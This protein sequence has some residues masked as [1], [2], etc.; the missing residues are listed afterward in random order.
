MMAAPLPHAPLPQV[1]LPRAPERLQRARA[2]QLMGAGVSRPRQAPTARRIAQRRVVVLMTK[3]SLPVL[4]LALLGSVALWPELARLKDQGRIAFRR[5][6]A[7]DPDSTRLKEPRYRG[8][9][10]RGRPFT[11]TGDWAQQTSPQR[12]LLGEPKG[13]MVTENGTWL[14]VQSHDGVYIQHAGQLDLSRDVVLYREDG[15]VLRTQTA[16][17]D[18]KQGAA[19]SNDQT[20]AEGPFGV[21]DSQGF[22]LTDK[23]GAIQFYGPARLI[24]NGASR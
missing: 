3:W 15:T 20:H 18:T 19:S 1:P 21:L 10:E 16:A 17:L 12:V 14:M 4:A 23:G 11:I 24:L 5:A 6:F 13:D 2:D 8:V 22:T 7:V 9:D